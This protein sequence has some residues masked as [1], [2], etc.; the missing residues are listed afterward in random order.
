MAGEYNATTGQLLAAASAAISRASQSA[1]NISR[2]SV[3]IT[4]PPFTYV[5]ETPTL[6]YAG[7]SPSFSY[8]PG[9]LDAGEPPKFSD[10]F[11]GADNSNPLI[12]EL[13]GIVD[14]LMEKYFPAINGSFKN[15]TEDWCASII[16]GTQPF[17]TSSTV[18]EMVWQKARDR[19]YRTA[20]SEQRQL[21]ASMSSRGFS[22]PIGALA[23]LISQSEQGATSAILDVSR[24]QAIKDADVKLELL[25]HATTIASQLK[26]GILGVSADYFRAYHAV[27]GTAIDKARIKAQLYNTY[28]S[29]LA[30][31]S[32]V[33]VA[34]EQ[35]RLEAART[36]ANI[37]LN[38]EDLKLRAAEAGAGINVTNE[39][40]KL[41]AAEARAGILTDA[42][43][44]K[45]GL[46]SGDAAPA[47][48]AQAAR[49]FADA[50]GSAYT[51][52]GTLAAEIK[53][54]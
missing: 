44:I 20:T 45:V 33:E 27:H 34:I 19:A 28:Y 1:S 11:D 3:S 53:T 18:F 8:T 47:A 38:G 48:H 12:S 25:K 16:G 21:E 41:R 49:A 36:A 42:N 51:A 6:T 46:Y 14:Q 39:Q 40:T 10:L 9:S 26:L 17:G 2:A 43:R 5:A 29:A 54:S 37:S 13:N 7:N 50:G 24:D 52:M 15:L 35:V 31:Y 4:T 22:M 30:S 23:D 32:N